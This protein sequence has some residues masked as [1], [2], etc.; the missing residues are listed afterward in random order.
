M[1][2][3]PHSQ[4]PRLSRTRAALLVLALLWAQALGLAHRIQHAPGASAVALEARERLNEPGHA[5]HSAQ[6]RLYDHLVAGDLLPAT[7]PAAPL[8]WGGE[9]FV[10]S[11]TP[12]TAAPSPHGYQARA[13]PRRA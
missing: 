8:A 11:A 10:G 5:P 12:I 4:P 6:C 13:P 2:A 3:R 1:S 7:A 9:A